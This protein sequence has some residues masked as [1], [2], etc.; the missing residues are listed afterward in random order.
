MLVFQ[1]SQF[2][3]QIYPQKRLALETHGFRSFTSTMLNEMG[4]RPDVIERQL[5]HSERNEVREHTTA[6]STFRSG[7][8]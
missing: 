3:P 8:Q 4:F 7:E 1:D 5:A 6:L 2:Y